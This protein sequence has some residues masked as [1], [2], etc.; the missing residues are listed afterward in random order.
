[1]TLGRYLSIYLSRS[2]LKH[3]LIST[4]LS[5]R[6]CALFDT[7]STTQAE[8][9]R[10]EQGLHMIVNSVNTILASI[11][12]DFSGALQNE[13]WTALEREIRPQECGIYSY[14]PEPDSDPFAGNGTLYVHNSIV[15]S[16]YSMPAINQSSNQ[17][18]NQSIASCS[19]RCIE[20]H[21]ARWHRWSFY[22]FFFNKRLKRIVFF[23]CR[24]SNRFSNVDS[25]PAT[26]GSEYTNTD[27]TRSSPLASDD[28]GYAFYLVAWLR[29]CACTH[30]DCVN[31]K[32][33]YYMEEMEM[34]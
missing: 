7:Y 22:Y 4:P 9:F 8:E 24:A 6:I 16:T 20:T 3:T 26:T 28:E 32:Y 15:H 31:S 19:I 1:M 2:R 14:Q 21:A 5:T 30:H 27:E 18:I 25:F 11:I 17:S 12:P 23:A 29:G 34:E 33:S 10:R 13:I